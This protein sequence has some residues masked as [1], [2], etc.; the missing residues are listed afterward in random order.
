M[1]KFN[2]GSFVTTI[3]HLCPLAS[4]FTMKMNIFWKQKFSAPQV[5]SFAVVHWIH[6]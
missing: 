6:I 4:Y 5:N 1:F 3:W 2:V